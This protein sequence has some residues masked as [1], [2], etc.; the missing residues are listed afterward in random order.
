MRQACPVGGHS[1]CAGYGPQ[2]DRLFI[3]S[4]ITHDADRMDRQQHGERLPDLFVKIEIVQLLDKDPIGFLQQLDLFG[5][6]LAE[7]S[8]A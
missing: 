2:S 7:Y 4:I 3:R 5:R 8:N 1:V 6:D